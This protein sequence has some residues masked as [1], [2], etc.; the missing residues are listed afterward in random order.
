MIL[1]TDTFSQ[2]DKYLS[3]F[4]K[5][6]KSPRIEK[7]KQKRIYISL[8]RYKKKYKRKITPEDIENFLIKDGDT[9]IQIDNKDFY[10]K[11]VSVPYEPKDST[12][13]EA[14]K[15]VVYLKYH[16]KK[17]KKEIRLRYW[18][19]E[20]RIFMT[21]N[22]DRK[23]KKELKK[24]TKYLSKEVDSL[25]ISFV[26]K[27][28]KSNY[29]IYGINSNTDYNY[30]PKI[31][32]KKVSYYIFWNGKQQIYNAKL[33]IDSR[34]YENKEDL[35]LKT[36]KQFLKTLGMF[37]WSYKLPKEGYFSLKYFKKKEFTKLD[38]EILKYHYSYGICKGMTLKLF[39]QAHENAKNLFKK[40]G[41]NIQFKHIN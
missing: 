41:R 2:V 31:K 23:V 5:K 34:A 7:T 14:Y 38:L 25:K 9:L 15:D 8:S 40:T 18:K 27:L 36:K 33:K 20:I 30:E 37:H 17:P 4:K 12:F 39:E 22:I 3:S 21:K 29:I 11:G 16:S 19:D 10:K 35:I 1:V 32:Q 26:N 6:F 24:F 13:L 28:E